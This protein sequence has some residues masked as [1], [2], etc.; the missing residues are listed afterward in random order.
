MMTKNDEDRFVRNKEK[1]EDSFWVY[2]GCRN[3]KREKN[4]HTKDVNEG[5]KERR[6]KRGRVRGRKNFLPRLLV[7]TRT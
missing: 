5:R 6:R 3:R 7:K 2:N 1:C 4:F